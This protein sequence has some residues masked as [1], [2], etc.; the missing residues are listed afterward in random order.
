MEPPSCRRRSGAGGTK[1]RRNSDREPGS[2]SHGWHGAPHNGTEKR[3]GCHSDHTPKRDRRYCSQN[4]RA[5][6]PCPDRD[7]QVGPR[8][9]YH[10]QS[11]SSANKKSRRPRQR[12]LDW[13]CG[14]DLRNPEFVTRMRG[15]RILRRQLS[16]DEASVR[17]PKR[18]TRDDC[19]RSTE[20]DRRCSNRMFAEG[21]HVDVN[22]GN[23]HFC[24]AC[25][26]ASVPRL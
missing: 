24:G 5:T 15:E 8:D 3:C 23:G 19:C 4:D 26:L 18:W 9:H 10:E 13:P 2:A 22:K 1:A 20:V 14:G 6:R 21:T 12:C 7:Q 25:R 17:T 11:D 16:G